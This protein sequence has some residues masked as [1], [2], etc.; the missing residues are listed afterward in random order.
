MDDPP[1]SSSSSVDSSSSSSKLIA[2]TMRPH[3][4]YLGDFGEYFSEQ[5][6]VLKLVLSY[7]NYYDLKTLRSVNS[8]FRTATD[9]LLKKRVW[10]HYTSLNYMH[11]TDHRPEPLHNG[12]YID[13]RIEPKVLFTFEGTVGGP[14]SRSRPKICMRLRDRNDNRFFPKSDIVPNSVRTFVPIG[15]KGIIYPDKNEKKETVIVQ[16]MTHK[17]LALL[18]LPTNENYDVSVFTRVLSSDTFDQE[19]IRTF[20]T[21]DP[22]P[23]KGLIFLKVGATHIDGMIWFIVKLVTNNQSES[24]ALSGGHVSS[25]D[26]DNPPKKNVPGVLKAIIF[27]GE[28]VRCVSDVIGSTTDDGVLEGLK[29]TSIHVEKTLGKLAPDKSFIMMFQCVDRHSMPIEDHTHLAKTFPNI[30]IFGVQTWGEIGFSSFEPQQELC[31]KF[32]P[33]KRK[34]SIM[35][36]VKTTYIIVSLD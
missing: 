25:L 24:F 2:N 32:I 12:H 30:P 17:K 29:N 4:P 18:Y 20:F 13:L 36:S 26:C 14:S 7:L 33:K 16:T 3:S 31:R 5:Y 35:H 21:S 19:S 22:R 11:G 9:I 1:C 8:S 10:I 23:I 34:L 15:A 6:S 28:G 27:R